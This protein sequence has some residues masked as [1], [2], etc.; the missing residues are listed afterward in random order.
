M[1]DCLV[2]FVELGDRTNVVALALGAGADRLGARHGVC[3]LLERRKRLDSPKRIPPG[4]ERNTPHGDP[5]LGI[6]LEH[7]FEPVRRGKKRERVQQR[8]GA[9]ECRPRRRR[10]RRRE[11][12][13]AETFWNGVLVL[14]VGLCKGWVFDAHQA[15]NDQDEIDEVGVA[16]AHQVLRKRTSIAG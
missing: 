8:R 10:T 14:M 9:I 11:I 6:L 15:K 16:T 13:R 4:A 1:I 3:A 12:D 2:I 5:A 7:L